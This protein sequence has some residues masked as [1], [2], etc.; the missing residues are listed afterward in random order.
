MRCSNQFLLNHTDASISAEFYFSPNGLFAS[1]NPVDV[2]IDESFN[3]VDSL[4]S[5]QDFTRLLGCEQHLKDTESIEDF[6]ECVSDAL[7]ELN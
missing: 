6:R 3:L 2:A 7:D 1:E 4:D 5:Y